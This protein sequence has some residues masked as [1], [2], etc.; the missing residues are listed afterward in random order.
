MENGKIANNLAHRLRE[1]IE[2]LQL[3]PFKFEKEIGIG[4]NTLKRPLSDTDST[5]GVDK[6]VLMSE[7]FKEINYDYLITGRGPYYYKELAEFPERRELSELQ[8]K[9]TDAEQKVEEYRTK[10][11]AV[12]EEYTRC[13]K[14][15]DAQ[16]TVA[17]GRAPH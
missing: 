5:F 9:L 4:K 3:T 13:L 2:L 16:K 8:K 7:R 12:L 11:E 1:I 14:E 10:Y 15:K 6:L 17:V